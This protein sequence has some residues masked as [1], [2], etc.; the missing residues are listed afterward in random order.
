M[1]GWPHVQLGLLGWFPFARSVAS[2]ALIVA[3]TGYLVG[4]MLPDAR[5]IAYL[6]AAV[7]AVIS[8]VLTPSWSTRLAAIAIGATNILLLMGRYPTEPP[9]AD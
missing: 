3:A 2:I 1:D 5:R 7:A 9:P 8:M 4:L 6:V